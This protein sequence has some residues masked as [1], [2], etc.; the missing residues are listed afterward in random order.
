VISFTPRPLYPQG[1]SPRYPFDRRLMTTF[2][3]PQNSKPFIIVLAFSAKNRRER[4]KN[5]RK[6]EEI[7]DEIEANRERKERPLGYG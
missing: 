5:G 6:E 2:V 3:L 7:N 4:R 1:R